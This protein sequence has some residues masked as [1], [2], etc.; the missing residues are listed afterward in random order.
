MVL[1]R[2]VGVSMV[3]SGCGSELIDVDSNRYCESCAIA[4]TQGLCTTLSSVCVV[5]S[6]WFP[7]VSGGLCSVGVVSVSFD[8]AVGHFG[9]FFARCGIFSLDVAVDSS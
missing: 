9:R 5:V 8:V 6:C 3:W 4:V 1:L 7:D 2:R